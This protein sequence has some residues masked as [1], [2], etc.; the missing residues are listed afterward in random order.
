MSKFLT[1]TID[2]LLI[3]NFQ[4]NFQCLLYSAHRTQSYLFAPGTRKNIKSHLRQYILFC[5]KFS[6]RI[7]PA[8]RDTLTAFFELFSITASY[9]HLKNV[10]S[11]IK[12][13]HQ[14]LNQ[15][16]L[17]EEFQV[18]TV[19]QAIK[20][21]I[22]RVPFQVLPIT[23]KIL[24]DMYNF[25][26]LRKP[27]DLA[28]WS[29]FLVAF[30]CLFRKSNVAPKSLETFNCLKDLSRRKVSFLDSDGIVLVYSNWR[31]TNQFMSRNTVIPLIRNQTLALYPFSVD[32]LGGVNSRRSC[33]R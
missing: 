32:P 15:P 12:F 1:M 22:A 29:S 16:F 14:A 8:D 25:I 9:N 10:Y 24:C 3:G 21:K 6:R 28:L 33:V 5:C 19:L 18:N 27:S 4:D 30:Y 7:V 23:P 26:D 2:S 20:R 31:K 13:L 11:S 17:E